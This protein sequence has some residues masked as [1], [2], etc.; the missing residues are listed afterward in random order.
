MN[1]FNL[2]FSCENIARQIKNIDF[3][4]NTT[5]ELIR[6][7]C[8]YGGEV[9]K[10]EEVHEPDTGNEALD[11]LAGGV[12]GGEGGGEQQPRAGHQPAVAQSVK[13]HPGHQ[14]AQEVH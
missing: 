6:D 14:P 2:R 4:T 8:W 7:L 13:Q 11:V 12:E 1:V 3:E 5:I 10:A 9:C